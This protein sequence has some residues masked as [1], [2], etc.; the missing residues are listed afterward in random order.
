MK[1]LNLKGIR[2]SAVVKPEAGDRVGEPEPPLE[3]LRILANS[4]EEEVSSGHEESLLR[5][6]YEKTLEEK[7]HSR[8]VL[9]MASEEN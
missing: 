4:R 7:D 1:P 6:V 5:I 2:G 9:D 3:S 8:D